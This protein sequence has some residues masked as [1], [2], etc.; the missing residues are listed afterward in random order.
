LVESVS[1]RHGSPIGQPIYSEAARITGR[2]GKASDS[3]KF[4][5]V[6][7]AIIKKDAHN[8]RPLINSN[9]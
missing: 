6:R 7:W 3:G 5:L 1:D 4:N 8:R 9:F 2:Q